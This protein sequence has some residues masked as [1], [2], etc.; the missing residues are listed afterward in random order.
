MDMV[1]FRGALA[2]MNYVYTMY[3]TDILFLRRIAISKE[4]LEPYICVVL[5]LFQE[6]SCSNLVFSRALCFFET[7]T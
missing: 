3:L 1:F 4:H 7:S 2:V 6:A 5:S